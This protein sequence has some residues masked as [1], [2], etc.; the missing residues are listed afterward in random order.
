MY[1]DRLQQI[2]DKYQ[3]TEAAQTE[4]QQLL[5]ELVEQESAG[6]EDSYDSS[7]QLPGVQDLIECDDRQYM[8]A[9]DRQEYDHRYNMS[10][11]KSHTTMRGLAI[12][13]TVP[14]STYLDDAMVFLTAS[15]NDTSDRR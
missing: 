7:P 9:Q 3:I 11:A 6:T 12:P 14:Y 8:Q 15:A 1:K 4:L 2:L 5:K 13:A 10:P